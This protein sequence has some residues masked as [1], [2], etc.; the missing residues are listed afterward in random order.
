MKKVIRY[1]FLFTI[2]LVTNFGIHNY[3]FVKQ[4]TPYLTEDERIEIAM[5]MLET[6]LPAYIIASILFVCAAH[7]LVSKA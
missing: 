7:W 2:A 5:M 6:T 3:S 1:S 4:A